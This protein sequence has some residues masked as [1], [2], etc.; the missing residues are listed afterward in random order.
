M[1]DE[2][3]GLP[4]HRHALLMMHAY[5]RIWRLAF[6]EMPRVLTFKARI[7]LLSFHAAL[8][9]AALWVHALWTVYA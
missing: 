4:A 1:R 3:H 2:G 9:L 7:W 6:G 5:L 8:I